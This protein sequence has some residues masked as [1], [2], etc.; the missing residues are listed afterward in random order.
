MRRAFAWTLLFLF[1]Y[2]LAMPLFASGPGYT[3]LPICCR[4]NGKH[5]CAMTV[6]AAYSDGSAIRQISDHCPYFPIS[7][8]ALQSNTFKPGL[9]QVFDSAPSVSP[10]RI[11]ETE[12]HYHLSWSRSRQK[13][14]PPTN[15][16]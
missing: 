2:A 10:S 12:A 13:R 15:L 8:A 1:S 16:L 6:Q 14:G 9:R 7:T 3:N 11:A 4:R 5:H